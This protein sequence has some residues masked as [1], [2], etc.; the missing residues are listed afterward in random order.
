MKKLALFSMLFVALSVMAQEKPVVEFNERT[1]D[2]GTVKEEEGKI[3]TVFTFTNQFLAPLT[4]KSVRAS[5]GCTTPNWSKEPVAPKGKGEIT[6]TYNTTNRPGS[7]TKSITVVLTNGTEDF[8]EV[9]YIK[10][11]VT[12]KAVAPTAEVK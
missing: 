10:G 1:H 7:F 8:T 9:L 4:I 5:C 2:F 6:V 12:P 3:T 11:Q